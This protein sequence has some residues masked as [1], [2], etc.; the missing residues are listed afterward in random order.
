MRT[1]ARARTVMR[2]VVVAK[3]DAAKLGASEGDERPGD[4]RAA[5][6]NLPIGQRAHVVEAEG[7]DGRGV[8]VKR[9]EVARSGQVGAGQDEDHPPPVGQTVRGDMTRSALAQSAWAARGLWGVLC[10]LAPV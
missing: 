1:E 7:E 10:S 9:I 6:V 3:L 4:G 2:I 8:V 5:K